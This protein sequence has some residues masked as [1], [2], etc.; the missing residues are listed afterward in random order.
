[1]IP[2]D[3]SIA[4]TRGMPMGGARAAINSRG[5]SHG[6]HGATN[7]AAAQRLSTAA[8]D[9]APNTPTRPTSWA[10]CQPKDALWACCTSI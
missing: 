8:T 9:T 5:D 3:P 7:Q 10:S 1:M 2:L 6:A 4:H